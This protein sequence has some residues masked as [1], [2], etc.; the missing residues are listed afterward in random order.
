MVL[1]ATQEGIITK[2]DAAQAVNS[3]V[4]TNFRLSDGIIQ[5]ALSLIERV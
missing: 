5:K 1:M 4:K 3:L 2:K